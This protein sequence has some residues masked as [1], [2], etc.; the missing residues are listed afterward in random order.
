ML[1]HY[2]KISWRNIIR[3]KIFTVI[4]IAGLALGIC[5]CIVIFLIT[6]FELSF[7]N[8]HPDKER[9]YHI[10]QKD[11]ITPSNVSRI[12][13]PMP[14]ALRQEITG[15]EAVASFY[16]YDASITP[17]NEK[18]LHTFNSGI[19]GSD[20]TSVII[21][22]LHYFDIFKFDWLA[23]KPTTS[24]QQPFKVVLSESKAHKYFGS[25]PYDNIIGREL[26]YNDSLHVT[27]SGIVKDWNKNTDF[28]YTEFISYSSIN[29]SNF[30]K[31]TYRTDDWSRNSAGMWCMIKLSKNS[32][33][34]QI[35]SQLKDF[36]KR[37]LP[38]NPDKLEFL[39]QPLS[40]IHFNADY[41]HDDIRK[42]DLP[43]IRFLIGIA[44]FILILAIV[45]FI[46]LSTAQSIQ[47]I[48]EIGVRKVLGSSRANLIFQ[49]L[50][51]TF[52]VSFFAV[53][54]AM[55]M[56]APLLSFFQDFI[57]PRLSF[58]FFNKETLLFLLMLILVI[59]L[60]AGLYPAKVLSSYIPALSLKGDG[61]QSVGKK[62][63]MR[64]GLVI[65][66]FTISL[67]FIIGTLVISKQINF[68]LHA[69]YGLKTNAILDVF[70]TKG[71]SKWKVLKEKIKEL[72]EVKKVILQG[73]APTGWVT[74]FGKISFTGKNH[75]VIK[76]K[77][78]IDNGNEEFIPF[79]Q[80]RLVAGRN[81]L[82]SDSLQEFIIN[83][84]CRKNL[85]FA[86]PED[87][88]GQLLTYHKKAFPIVGVVA[89]FHEGSFHYLIAPLMIGHEPGDEEDFGIQLVTNENK[90][91]N[92]KAELSAIEKVY[93]DIYPRNEFNYRIIDECIPLLY[94]TDQK[95][96][97]LILAA[98]LITV[99]ISC[100]GL[101]GLAMFT[102]KRRTKEISIRKVIGASISDI[103][104][105]LTKD[106][107][108]VILI[109]F[110]IASPIAW[111]FM[112]KWLENFAYRIDISWWIF[113]FAVMITI[114]IA[115][116]TISFQAIKAAVVNPV[117]SLR[118]E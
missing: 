104:A 4:N 52:V 26:T 5:T 110:L 90:V 92:M 13:P 20:Q 109:A 87:A 88:I 44:L 70:I 6:N 86:K 1:K 118:T 103:I 82:R 48:K 79:Y 58:Q 36:V 29:S 112:N 75:Q 106:Y 95:T 85:G 10:G 41:S 98:T 9:I 46:N 59:P 111:F 116:A 7:D 78:Q 94:D 39:L 15:I 2:F 67:I 51:E 57:P 65:F 27:V 8:F 71:N 62:W 101:F 18:G 84:T 72:P 66:Q 69:D 28:P 107:V 63:L 17:G 33:A 42:A 49:F 24:L 61:C 81:L 60:L 115:F 30:L 80:M 43:T 68:V 16:P 77:I 105:L 114:L 96:S 23:G 22:D 73:T 32:T 45:N 89:D 93:K 19:E 74:R 21:T 113:L 54:I 34:F 47:R 83:E 117:K 56:V 99:F 97:K 76:M 64:K 12:S 50:T 31:T 3:N 102:A 35:K 38:G 108:V 100:I 40:D 37:H 25:L 55:L 14:D 53:C 11:P 91:S